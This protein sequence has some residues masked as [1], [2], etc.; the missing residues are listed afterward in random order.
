MKKNR[1]SIF[2]VQLDIST[3]EFHNYYAQNINSVIAS[4]HT[5]QRVQFPANVL[6]PF[7]SHA[8]VQG[9]FK[10]VI[11]ENAKFKSIDRVG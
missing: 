8:G 10:L 11:D 3:V 6:Q 2:Y 5:G 7:V 9:C 1:E 4:S